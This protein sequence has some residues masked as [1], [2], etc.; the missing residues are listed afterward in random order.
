MLV[1][2]YLASFYHYVNY[3]VSDPRVNDWPLMHTPWPGATILGLYLMFVLKWGPK[4]MEHRKPF[5]IDTIIKYYNL[6]QVFICAYLF[7]EGLRLGYLRGYSFLCQPVDYTPTEVPT[8]IAKR[9]Y[10]YFLVKVLDLLDTIFF[11]LRKKQNQVSFLHVYHHTGMVMLIWSGVKW[12]PGGHGVFMGF[13]NS[14]VHVVM[15]FYYFLTS[16][17][18]KYKANLWWKKYITQLQ[19]IQFGMIFLQWFVLLFQPNC[20]FPKWPLFVIL[21]QNLFMFFLFLDFYYKAYMKKKPTAAKPRLSNEPAQNGKTCDDLNGHTNVNHD[22]SNCIKR[23]SSK[24][25]TA[26]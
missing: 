26:S 9:C 17:S 21:P 20:A 10:Y 12:F 6:A 22:G 18:P 8:L 2:R 11:V 24:E 5:R 25:V 14:F 16:V 3:E 1:L 4:W 23:N 15:Y 13:I 19:I 7:I